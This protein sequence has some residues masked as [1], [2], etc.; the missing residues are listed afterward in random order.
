M[1]ASRKARARPKALPADSVRLGWKTYKCL[2]GRS[3]DDVAHILQLARIEVT[4][5]LAAVKNYPAERM[6]VYGLPHLES[7]QGTVATLEV[8]VAARRL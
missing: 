3:L 8:H 5:Y 2:S 1:A 4:N 7:L 6:R